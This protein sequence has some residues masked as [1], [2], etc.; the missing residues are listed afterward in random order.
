MRR[1]IMLTTITA[2]ATALTVG[3]IAATA[4]NGSSNAVGGMHA[5]HAMTAGK[6][7]KSDLRNTLNQLLGEHAILAMNATNAGV[8]G[9]KSFPA[10]AKAL[11]QNSVALSVIPSL[12]LTDRGL[13][14]VDRFEIVP[15]AAGEPA[16]LPRS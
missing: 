6:L 7:T 4:G 10:A 14:D 3:V 9:S 16:G 1:S 13:V 12:K 2:A 15:L 8:T 11:D 5:S